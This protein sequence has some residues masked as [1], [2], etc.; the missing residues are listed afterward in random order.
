MTGWE[1]GLVPA[2]ILIESSS[3][4]KSPFPTCYQLEVC[5]SLSGFHGKVA[6][7]ISCCRV[8]RF[9]ELPFNAVTSIV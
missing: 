2:G 6:E 3:G 7:K 5:R 4:D 1:E 8:H 9:V